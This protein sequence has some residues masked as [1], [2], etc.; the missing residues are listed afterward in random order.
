MKRY[1]T[2]PLEKSK[3]KKTFDNNDPLFKCNKTINA[4]INSKLN[5]IEKKNIN[6]NNKI[7]KPKR[8]LPNKLIGNQYTINSS[9]STMISEKSNNKE[10]NTSPNKNLNNEN[11]KLNE[12]IENINNIKLEIKKEKIIE[13]NEQLKERLKISRNKVSNL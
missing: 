13:E 11:E 10:I 12:Q 3:Q 1:N 9:T 2:G 8:R 7:P 6:N 4:Y 5:N